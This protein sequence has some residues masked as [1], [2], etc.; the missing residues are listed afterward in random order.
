MTKLR[1]N[2]ICSIRG[3]YDLGTWGSMHVEDKTKDTNQSTNGERHYIPATFIRR[4][5]LRKS[6][7]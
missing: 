4:G 7:L 2:T 6:E 3:D 5:F 1:R